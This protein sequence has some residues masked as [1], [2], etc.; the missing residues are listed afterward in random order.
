[1][2]SLLPSPS[3]E[4]LPLQTRRGADIPNH[5][6]RVAATI[7]QTWDD[8]EQERAHR[9]LCRRSPA[10]PNYNCHGMTFAARRVWVPELVSILDDDGYVEIEEREV[11]PGDIA[12]YFA[13]TTGFL[14]H[15]GVV[16][17][18]PTVVA[19]TAMICSKWGAGG[20][21]IHAAHASPYSGGATIKYYRLLKIT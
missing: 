18:S 6:D 2:A 14:E 21:F 16:V 5:L 20:E 4:S 10:N 19:G 11:L 8:R 13:Q 15:S 17:Q 9:P 3:G 12:I 7:N 1:M